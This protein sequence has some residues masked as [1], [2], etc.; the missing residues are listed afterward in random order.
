MEWYIK[1]MAYSTESLY[2]AHSYN[3]L[4]VFPLGIISSANGNDQKSE[5]N[6][7]PKINKDQAINM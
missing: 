5:K 4:C 2:I 6:R 7:Y 3:I 1:I